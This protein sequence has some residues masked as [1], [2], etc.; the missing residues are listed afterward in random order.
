MSLLT[1]FRGYGILSVALALFSAS[2]FFSF[3]KILNEEEQISST[4]EEN[5]VWTPTEAEVDLFRLLDTLREYAIPDSATNH[6]ELQLRF[7]VLAGRLKRLNEGGNAAKLRE[8]EGAEG[9]VTDLVARLNAIG[10]EIAGLKKGDRAAAAVV[11][12]GL[13]LFSGPL[14][15]LTVNTLQQADQ[16][17]ESQRQRL[18]EAYL[19][20][21]IY[22]AGVAVAGT[23]LLLLLFRGMGRANRLLTERELT[24]ERLRDSEQRFRDYAS[25]SSD[26]LW[27]TDERGRFTYFSKGYL[28][29][30]GLDALAILGKTH[31]EI[32]LVAGDEAAWQRQTEV[33]A[34][35]EPF[36][37]FKYRM[38]AQGAVRHIKVS[39]V[40]FFDPEGAFLGYRGTGTDLTVQV[41][42][43]IEAMRART[44]LAEAVESLDEGFAVFDPQD[45]L[46]QCNTRFREIYGEAGHGPEP[47]QHFETIMRGAA[48]RGAFP[49][50]L[51]REEA[52][53]AERLAQHRQ[54]HGPYDFRV[55]DGRWI[56]ARETIL[57]NRWQVGTFIDITYQKRREEAL[58]REALIWGQMSDGV[59]VTDLE[60]RIT[61]WNPAAERMFGYPAAE[62]IGQTPRLLEGPDGHD[63]L[64]TAL[65][66]VERQGGW[67]GEFAFRRKDGS[68]GTADTVVVPLRDDG[69]NRIAIIWVNH[70]ITL[71][72]ESEVELV[73]AKEQAE[74]ASRA[75]SQFLATMSHEIR[76]PMNGMLGMIDLLLD[77]KL[78]REQQSYAETARKSGEALVAIIDDILDFSKMEAG[79]LDLEHAEFELRRLVEGVVDLLAPRALEKGVEIA[80]FIA[81]EVPDAVAGDPGRLRQI[82]LNLAGNSVKFTEEGGVSLLVSLA[83]AAGR[84]AR[85][86]FE[87]VDTGI[88]IP[89]EQRHGLFAEF[90]QVDPSYSRR[91]GGTGL[92]LAISKKLTELMGG[93]IGF[94]SEL[95]RGSTFWFTVELECRARAEGATPPLAALAQARVLVV[96]DNPVSAGILER[97]LAALGLAV[98][99]TGDP[100]TALVVL[101]GA[102]RSRQPFALALID[103]QLGGQSG[104]DLAAAIRRQSA[105]AATRLVL[106]APLGG[107]SEA[108]AAAGRS[109]EAVL[110]KPVHQETLADALAQLAAA[111]KAR[112]RIS[113]RPRAAA[114]RAVPQGAA[115]RLA[116]A[117]L[118]LVEDSPVNQMVATAM[119]A[120]LVGAVD[121]AENGREAIAAVQAKDYDVILMDVA[122]PEMD[123]LE[124]TRAIRAMPAPK[125]R[126]PI[127]AMT[128]HALESDRRRC[129]DAGMNDYVTKPIE[130][131]KLIETVARWLPQRASGEPAAAAPESALPENASPGSARGPFEKALEAALQAPGP[132]TAAALR[133]ALEGAL[134]P[135][136]AA[137]AAG[138][139]LEG[140]ADTA[141]LDDATLAQLEA[142]T[143]AAVAQDLVKTFVLETVARVDHIAHAAEAR[144][145]ATLER[146]AH[147]LKS[148]SGTFGALALAERAKAVEFAC[149]NGEGE[150]AVALA[151]NL[152]ALVASA[153]HAMVRHF[154]AAG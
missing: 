127:V 104:E 135:A 86:K 150:T 121:T 51:G 49:E 147:S 65:A 31:E 120:K 75:K 68:A 44:L 96:D 87:I 7:D 66:A 40:P 62:A 36:R 132:E 69:G 77:A 46:V 26:W 82:L 99:A 141:A 113:P 108:D 115:R 90:T 148:S 25:S 22:F 133:E 85:V 103:Q 101:D 84:R 94:T 91:Y 73:A 47:G 27:E 134:A 39:G 136:A 110:N 59:I 12:D 100:D 5:V 4:A 19:R 32:A 89:E 23:L 10:A 146:E 88:G 50:A 154:Q 139:V 143:D 80:A 119:L 140:G 76:T 17:V 105:L 153:A 116:R 1:R 142:D 102:A 70:D 13:R 52:W 126:V 95:G 16:L 72:K 129:L 67:S 78:A 56:Q 97:Q 57:E 79:K 54:T 21:V 35:H 61:N 11:I 137:V 128:A 112:G 14:N 149:K 114:S 74:L 60:G 55:K 58:R 33:M 48:F 6:D 130:R 37:D 145:F 123:G 9:I 131:A 117:R 64:A 107:R 109:F 24:E 43:E 2:I 38:A 83:E 34:H 124:A 29:K 111:G 30:V 81:P 18:R 98:T 71:R 93:T 138:A 122:M 20:L 118:L 92:G 152:P 106:L 3:D 41:E 8:I 144:D 45:R 63:L 15:T 151:G 125:G 42:A 53:V 28:E